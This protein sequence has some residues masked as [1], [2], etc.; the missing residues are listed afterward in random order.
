MSTAKRGRVR[1]CENLNLPSIL[2]F[3][4]RKE[5]SANEVAEGIIGEIVSTVIARAEKRTEKH[6]GDSV[7]EKQFVSWKRD[8]HWLQVEGSGIETHYPWIES[9]RCYTRTKKG[10]TLSQIQT[11]SDISAADDLLKV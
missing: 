7:S 6:R 1:K 2:G 8:F 9:P 4:T 5:P 11:L 10:L 3:V